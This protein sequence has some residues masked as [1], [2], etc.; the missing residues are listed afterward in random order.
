MPADK[1]T[2]VHYKGKTFDVLP[3]VANNQADVGRASEYQAYQQLRLVNKLSNENLEA[4]EM[5]ETAS[6]G[7]GW[8]GWG[9]WAWAGVRAGINP[10]QANPR[11]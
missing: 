3:D 10:S 1:V 11:L 4:A 6:M 2:L 9:G 7:W 8:G 5:N